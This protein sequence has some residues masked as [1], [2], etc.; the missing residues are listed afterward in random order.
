M[1]VT[2]D[3]LRALV[4]FVFPPTC[5]SCHRIEGVEALPLGLCKLCRSRLLSARKNS[6]PTTN[7]RLQEC[8]RVY[9]RWFYEPPLD[10]VIH[11]LKYGRMD[12]L[13]RD[14]AAALH[15][16]FLEALQEE[17][18]IVPIP[19]HSYRRLTRG[20]NQAEVIARPL[21]DLLG[22][23]LVRALRRRRFTRP[24]TRLDRWERQANLERAF[25]VAP[26]KVNNLVGRRVL[27]VDDVTTTGATIEAAAGVIRRC[28]ATSVSAITAAR[29][30]EEDPDQQNRSQSGFDKSVVNSI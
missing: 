9:S 11:A 3:S 6:V 10:R 7:S 15:D 28:G 23:S 29:T 1:S 16:H 27:I 18:V 17:D 14:L 26:R 21:A 30:A 2:R 13:G 4:A 19:L 25:V 12:F 8:A 20:Y 22:V 24:Q 5:L